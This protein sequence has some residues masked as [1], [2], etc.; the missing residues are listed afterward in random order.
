MATTYLFRLFLHGDTNAPFE[1]VNV[2]FTTA[3]D[4]VDPDYYVATLNDSD[5][6]DFYFWLERSTGMR[7]HTVNPA[8]L[9]PET[10]WA[11]LLEQSNESPYVA[12]IEGD[13]P[14]TDE[15]EGDE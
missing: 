3:W 12:K 9:S 4:E 8:R 14:P 1:A 13:I 2:I 15:G 5:K 10:L 11:A 6:E 7:G